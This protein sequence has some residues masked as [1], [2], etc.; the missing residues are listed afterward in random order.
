MSGLRKIKI[1]W[2]ELRSYDLSPL[3]ALEQELFDAIVQEYKERRE[4]YQSS[5][6]EKKKR[7]RSFKAASPEREPSSS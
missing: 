5:G 7:R 1:R 4:A 3:M 2:D 6:K